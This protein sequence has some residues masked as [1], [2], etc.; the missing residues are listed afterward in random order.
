MKDDLGTEIL[1]CHLQ[2]DGKHRRH[3]LWYLKSNPIAQNELIYVPLYTKLEAKALDETC[4][5]EVMRMPVAVY[6]RGWDRGRYIEYE[7]WGDDF[8]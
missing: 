1:D 2:A 8:K 7:Y 6:K 5:P 4:L 3:C